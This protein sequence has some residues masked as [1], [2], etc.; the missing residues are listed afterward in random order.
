LNVATAAAV[1]LHALRDRGQ[2]V[3]DA[4]MTGMS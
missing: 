2:A 3:D 4:T 1:A